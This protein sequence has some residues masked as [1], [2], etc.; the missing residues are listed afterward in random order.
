MSRFEYPEP[1]AV[2]LARQCVR[3]SLSSNGEMI[4]VFARWHPGD[5]GEGEE[6]CNCYDDIYQE[7][8]AY[9]S[10]LNCYGTTY[11]NFKE[12]KRGWGIFTDTDIEDEFTNKRNGLYTPDVREMQMEG[13]PLIN[14][15]DF[16]ARVSYW[17]KT[18]PLVVEGV[19]SCGK[20]TR[21]SIRTGQRYGQAY[22]DIVGQRCRVTRL[23]DKHPIYT[24]PFDKYF[25][26]VTFN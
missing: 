18:K 10:C 25:E 6:R 22:Y 1:Y 8:A 20:V 7:R 21:E 4:L 12:V 24:F 5:D 26:E 14:A 11:K 19:Y 23:S 15:G 16:I 2:R 3:D 17:D 13:D 9:D